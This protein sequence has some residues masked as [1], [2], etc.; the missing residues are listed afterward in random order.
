MQGV[1]TRAAA[2]AALPVVAGA[3]S[4]QQEEKIAH[5][6]N[7]QVRAEAANFVEHFATCHAPMLAHASESGVEKTQ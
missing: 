5:R 1:A 3:R 6:P 2:I 7:R 4:V